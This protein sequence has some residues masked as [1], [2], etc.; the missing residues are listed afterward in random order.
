M[1][2]QSKNNKLIHT[3]P[4]IA[5]PHNT[6]QHGKKRGGNDGCVCVCVCVERSI[7]TPA[8]VVVVDC[9]VSEEMRCAAP[10]SRNAPALSPEAH[11]SIAAAV[12]FSFPRRAQSTGVSPSLS[13]TRRIE[14]SASNRRATHRLWPLY[15][16]VCSGFRFGCVCVAMRER[17]SGNKK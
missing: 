16:A 4:H 14:S 12:P 17:G 13:L 7:H 10:R 8:V 6:H 5:A 1:L 9:D 2:V 15:A 3:K 11:F